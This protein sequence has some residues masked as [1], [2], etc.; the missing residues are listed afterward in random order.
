LRV[1]RDGDSWRVHADPDPG[2]PELGVL[3]A[4]AVEIGDVLARQYDLAQ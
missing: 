2:V 4:H 1:I 3:I